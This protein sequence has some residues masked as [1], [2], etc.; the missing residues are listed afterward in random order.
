MAGRNGASLRCDLLGPLRVRRGEELLSFTSLSQQVM[1]AVVALHANRPIGRDQ[2]IDSIWGDAPPTY[3]VN[4]VQKRMSE[5]RHILE[6]ERPAGKP[7]RVLRWTDRGYLLTLPDDGLDMW[8]HRLELE[9]ARTERAN[10]HQRAA[11]QALHAAMQLWRGAPFDGLSSP[12]LDAERER[13]VEARITATEERIELE[14]ALEPDADVLPELRRLVAEHPLRDRLRALLMRALYRAGRPA[15]A[16]AAYHDARTYL[17]DEL[18]TDPAADLQDL[19]QQILRAD[20]DLHRAV[21]TTAAPPAP[22]PGAWRVPPAELPHAL[23]H[24][25]ARSGELRRLDALVTGAAVTRHM[26]IVAITGTAGVGKTALAIHWA[27]RVRDQF[28]DGQLYVNLRGFD[29]AGAVVDPTEAIRGFLDA[30]TP[31][32]QAIPVQLDGQ[33][34]LF[35]S[36]LAGRRMLIVLDNARDAEHVRPLLPGSAG[37]LVVVTSRNQLAGLVTTDGA[38]PLDVDLLTA[39]EAR[40]L[41]QRR[42]GQERV[43][44]EP[45]AVDQIVRACAHLPLALT[46]AAARARPA[47]PLASLA[48]ELADA[49]VGLDAFGGDDAMSDVRAVFSW[50]YLRLSGPA[51]RLFR[52]FGVHPPSPDVSLHAAASLAGVG[53]GQLRLLLGELTRANL[54]TER[55][56]AGF[57]MHD[58]L[59]AYATEMAGI[60]ESAEDRRAAAERAVDCY[61]QT[62]YA[63]DRLLAPHRDDPISIPPA[64]RGVITR[65]L[66]DDADALQ[67]F[68]GEHFGLIAAIRSAVE[69]GLDAHVWQLCWA[70]TH[71]FEYHAH[72]HDS[73]GTST[74]ALEAARRLGDPMAAA[75]VHELLSRPLARLGRFR[76]AEAHLEEALAYFERVGDL[77]GQAHLHR[78][79]CWVFELTGLYAAALAHAERALDLF[80]QA[81]DHRSGEARA[82]NAVGWL[83]A[84]LGSS[85]HA[86]L[87]CRQALTLQQE[88]GDRIG[89]AE[90]HDS[91]ALVYLRRGEHALSIDAYRRALAIYRTIGDRYDEAETLTALGDAWEAAGQEDAAHESWR[92]AA[93][94]FGVMPIARTG[95]SEVPARQSY[96]R[97][98][99]PGS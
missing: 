92:D 90:T 98:D 48:A 83:H 86:L 13:L 22:D 84:M 2:L 31:G 77:A 30:I 60:E 67:W 45:Q 29:P 75:V 61:L 81:G 65:K 23:A 25:A 66:L 24:F 99:A 78:I 69:L 79:M 8:E 34:A 63:A 64:G 5:L 28:P 72:W 70:L 42:L 73:V 53:L 36:L 12:L 55:R 87:C 4:L 18:G 40:G 3:A 7:S 96:R 80:R 35:R 9:R 74:A 33:A 1:L 46:I 68:V 39:D 56:P 17:R 6:P 14:L 71:H 54:L 44:A 97:R 58:L 32:P 50:S 52:L 16:L 43:A 37:C 95:G 11:A 26:V 10:G 21:A 49:K 88:I 38:H 59:R 76:E 89:E 15:E 57:A 82:L 47:L 91:L 93:A 85:D 20:P 19:Y 62:A 51:R 94:I 27:H 41:L